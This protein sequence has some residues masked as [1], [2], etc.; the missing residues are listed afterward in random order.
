MQTGLRSGPTKHQVLLYC[1]KEMCCHILVN[2]D[3][4][5]LCGRVLALSTK[6]HLQIEVL[7]VYIDQTLDG[8]VQFTWALFEASDQKYT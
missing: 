6:M 8:I 5:V 7:I 3:G 2:L 1:V 4:K